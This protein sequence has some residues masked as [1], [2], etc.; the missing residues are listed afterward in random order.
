MAITRKTSTDA[1]FA[2]PAIS[3]R[4]GPAVRRISVADAVRAIGILL[5]AREGLN[6]AYTRDDTIAN[7]QEWALDTLADF[8][9]EENERE[10]R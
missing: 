8:L 4:K 9:T 6:T 1:E 2:A 7:S 3:R 5:A 10:R